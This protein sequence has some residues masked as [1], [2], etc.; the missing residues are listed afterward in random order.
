[1]CMKV[2]PPKTK[3]TNSRLVVVPSPSCPS[4]FLPAHRATLPVSVSKCLILIQDI[5]HCTRLQAHAQPRGTRTT[6]SPTAAP[7]Y[8][9]QHSAILAH[10]ASVPPAGRDMYKVV[11][12]LDSGG[13]E[14][15]GGGPIGLLPI[16][17]ATCTPSH[18]DIFQLPHAAPRASRIVHSARHI[19]SH[20]PPKPQDA[21]E[22]PPHLPQHR[23]TPSVR[24]PQV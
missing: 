3:V 8:S 5:T 10:T 20:G 19:T 11:A 6:R 24:T 7:L 9:P 2:C 21:R 4:S 12:A 18:A 14:I 15:Q 16:V 17:I 1:M 23:A 22:R 13:D